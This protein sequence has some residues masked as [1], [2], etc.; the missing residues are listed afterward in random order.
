VRPVR[1]RCPLWGELQVA[2]ARLQE[3]RPRALAPV[4]GLPLERHT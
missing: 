1:P 4:R 3:V 2:E